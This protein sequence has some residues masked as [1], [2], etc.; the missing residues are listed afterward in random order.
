MIL[1]HLASSVQ[2]I[3]VSHHM[4]MPTEQ[5]DFQHDPQTNGN[6]VSKSDIPTW[7]PSIYKLIV[8][9]NWDENDTN[10]RQ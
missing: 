6:T 8:W 9:P 2:L 3:S 4:H 1:S 10:L 7:L 5:S